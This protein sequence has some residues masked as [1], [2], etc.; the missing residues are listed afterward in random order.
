MIRRLWA[1]LVRDMH[2]EM[3]YPISL[4]MQFL[5]VFSSVFAFYFL[6]E[7]IGD[8]IAG[9]E[10]AA[11]GEYFGFVLVGLAFSGYFGLGLTSFANELRT[12]Q[13]TGTLEAL[14]MTPTRLSTMVVGSASFSYLLTTVRIGFHLLLGMLLG[15]RFGGANWLAALAGLLLS[16]VA[17]ASIGIGAAAFILVYKRG[18]PIT[19]LVSTLA[20]LLGGVYYP[21][22]VLPVWLQPVARLLPITYS[23]EVM[24]GALLHRASWADL[25]PDMLALSLFCVLLLP[26]SLVVFRAAVHRA[27]VDGSLAHY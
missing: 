7:W 1:M 20:T 18:N 21:V 4:F 22:S 9:P 8:S 12:A 16:I 25:L 3:S 6:A 11:G 13:T 5:G 19:W 14:L 26:L 27:R 10:S 24:R 17:F 2:I 23:L 15:V